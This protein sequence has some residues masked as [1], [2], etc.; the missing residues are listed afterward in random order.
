M[1]LARTQ[2]LL[3][4]IASEYHFVHF[5]RAPSHCKRRRI[6]GSNYEKLCQLLLRKSFSSHHQ[7]TM[8]QL[9]PPTAVLFLHHL[10]HE[11]GNTLWTKQLKSLHGTRNT[12]NRV[13][14]GTSAGL[15]IAME[16]RPRKVTT[17][18]RLQR[19]A[20]VDANTASMCLFCVCQPSASQRRCNGRGRAQWAM[21]VA[22]LDTSRRIEVLRAVSSGGRFL[23]L[24]NM[25]D[26]MGLS[27]ST[28]NTIV[29]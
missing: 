8:N 16:Q 29:P 25:C 2:A 14:Q 22:Q 12:M 18:L 24:I 7:I 20:T 3:L 5:A 9:S 1:P 17:H 15:D 26:M 21:D 4:L 10:L 28:P 27:S 19:S 11:M 23:G 13:E 6:V